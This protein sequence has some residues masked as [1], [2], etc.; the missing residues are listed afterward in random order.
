V[1]S[2]DARVQGALEDDLAWGMARAQARSA[3]GIV[4]DVDT[5]EVMALASLPAST[6][7][8]APADFAQRQQANIFNRATNQ[9][10][11]WAA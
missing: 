3:A 7:M 4:L 8:P 9:I 6:P 2:I 5:G 1:L 10:S 11:S